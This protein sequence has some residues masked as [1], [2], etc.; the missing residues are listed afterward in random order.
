MS[1]QVL[2]GLGWWCWLEVPVVT[3]GWSASP[4]FVESVEPMKTGLGKLRLTFIQ[5]LHPVSAIR[6]TV[7]LHVVFRGQSHIVG[8]LQDENN[9]VRTAILTEPDFGW[10]ESYCPLLWRRRRPETPNLIFE[11]RPPPRGPTPSEYLDETLG[12]DALEVIEGATVDSFGTE[13]PPMPARTSRFVFDHLFNPFDSWM[14]ARGFVPAAMEDKWFIYLEGGRL[15]FRHSWTDTLIF[16]VEAMWRG[17]QLYLGEVCVNRDPE[18]Y[19]ETDDSYDSHLLAFLIVAI[20]L[21][22][23][24]DFPVRGDLSSEQA[25]LQAWSYAGRASL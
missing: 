22:E 20:L 18:E 21:G 4:V 7:D 23:Q 17:D 19:D 9:N 1:N 16:A 24:A 11:G 15:L 12:S 6:R 3:P 5:A 25:A 2:V 10:L 13:H 8:T 14:I